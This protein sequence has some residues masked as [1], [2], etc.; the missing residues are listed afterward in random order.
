VMPHRRDIETSLRLEQ[1]V[2]YCD[3]PVMLLFIH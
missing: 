3:E 1:R 2:A